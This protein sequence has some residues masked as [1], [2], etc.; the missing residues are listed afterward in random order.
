MI[1]EHDPCRQL[2][3]EWASSADTGPSFERTK[4]AGLVVRRHPFRIQVCWGRANGVPSEPHAL[5]HSLP[6][7]RAACDTG[8]S[9]DI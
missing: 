4:L 6:G 7:E 8:A 2:V 3:R 5:M 1:R 9:F